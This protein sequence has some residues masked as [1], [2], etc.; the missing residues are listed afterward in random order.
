MMC[1][2]LSSLSLEK[3]KARFWV[4][5]K[6]LIMPKIENHHKIVRALSPRLNIKKSLFAWQLRD[7]YSILM[8]YKLHSIFLWEANVFEFHF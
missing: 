5:A 3:E 8:S 2:F 7:I 1:V 6:G 4:F